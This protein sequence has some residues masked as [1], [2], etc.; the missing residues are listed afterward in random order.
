MLFFSVFL[1]FLSLEFIDILYSRSPV[2]KSLTPVSQMVPL[3]RN[4]VVEI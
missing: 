2:L 3:P 1:I 4:K